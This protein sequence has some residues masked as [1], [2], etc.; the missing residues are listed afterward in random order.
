[1]VLIVRRL[2]NRVKM[3]DESQNNKTE[4]KERDA[5]AQKLMYVL[6]TRKYY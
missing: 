1:M 4:K 2:V 3:E 6:Y 5:F